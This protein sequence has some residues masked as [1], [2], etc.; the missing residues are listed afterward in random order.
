MRDL[1]L[2]M[3]N[4]GIGEKNVLQ[5]ELTQH[6]G[7]ILFLP[8]ERKREELFLCVRNWLHY[9]SSSK[10][11]YICILSSIFMNKTNPTQK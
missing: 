3:H 11:Y 10:Y 9:T 1:H 2:T 7:E 8:D 6:S 5:D 4:R